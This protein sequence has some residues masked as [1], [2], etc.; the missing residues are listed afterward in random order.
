MPLLSTSATASLND[1]VLVEQLVGLGGDQRLVR[2]GHRHALGLGA[3]ALAENIG[4]VDRANRSAGHVRQF[5]HRHARA[6]LRQFD[7]DLLVVELARVQLA[8]EGFA[9]GGG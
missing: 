6:A 7:L 5:E 8:A 2:F 9:G 4:D 3:L 1:R